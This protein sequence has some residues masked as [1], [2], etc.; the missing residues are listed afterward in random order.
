MGASPAQALTISRSEIPK[1][2][3]QGELL[4]QLL[5]QQREGKGEAAAVHLPTEA[6]PAGRRRRVAGG[7]RSSGPG[8]PTAPPRCLAG[9]A[10]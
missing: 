4:E 7:V 5:A 2:S 6:P 10:Q 9:P 1:A 8:R 3:G